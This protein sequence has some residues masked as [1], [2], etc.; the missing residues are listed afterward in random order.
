M[1]A[2]AIPILIGVS[3]HVHIHIGT[4]SK[5]TCEPRRGMPKAAPLIWEPPANVALWEPEGFRHVKHTCVANSS[6]GKRSR[7]SVT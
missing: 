2:H 3:I 6:G 5:H 7:G 1:V 4:S